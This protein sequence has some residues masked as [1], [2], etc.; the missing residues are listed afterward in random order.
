[1][2]FRINS[3]IPAQNALRNLNITQNNL[4]GTVER[5]SSGLRI[6]K[7]KDDAAGLAI[8]E[9]MRSDV[10]VL[11]QGVRNANDAISV[12]QTAEGGMSQVNTILT[13]MK[14]LAMESAGV[15]PDNNDRAKLD[16]EFTALSD[17]LNRIASGTEFNG[18][19]L[20]DGTFVDKNVHIGLGNDQGVDKVSISI[21][22]RSGVDKAFTTAQLL[23]AA[24]DGA[25]SVF[26]ISTQDSAINVM[27]R[28]N[29]AIDN[30]N[31]AR[32]G[33]GALQSRFDQMIMNLDNTIENT[34]AAESQ[35]RD[36]DIAYETT[37]FTRFQ[38][39]QQSGVAMLAQ[40][41]VA[42]QSALSLL[43]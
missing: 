30:V 9:G 41:N 26:T 10:R 16:A 37:Q 31:A 4:N 24:N 43:G 5:L 28:I 42:P 17:E 6:N 14:E 21:S 32:A 34:S 23:D 15:L 2:A 29:T 39:L 13:R 1:M 25:T 36:A 38:I 8:S 40:A 7:A 27:A 19:S 18:T 22:S 12:I 3:N 11:R 33:L 20:L 35:I